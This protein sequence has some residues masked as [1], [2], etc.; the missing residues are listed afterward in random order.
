MPTLFAALCASQFSPLHPM[1]ANR[2]GDHQN[3]S[4]AANEPA[5]SSASKRRKESLGQRILGAPL[6][7]LKWAFSTKKKA[8]ISA[9]SIC[10]AYGLIT[11]QEESQLALIHAYLQSGC[12]NLQAYIL[13]MYSQYIEEFGGNTDSTSSSTAQD[14]IEKNLVSIT[15]AVASHVATATEPAPGYF[16]KGLESLAYLFA[17]NSSVCLPEENPV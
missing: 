6:K 13:E 5:K 8:F 16:E 4:D 2:G 17:S 9:L 11:N 10:L 15:D 1:E 7:G 3:A 12:T 14:L